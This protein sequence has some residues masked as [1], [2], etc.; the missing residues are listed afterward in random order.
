MERIH[1]K[2]FKMNDFKKLAATFSEKAYVTLDQ[3]TYAR[4]NLKFLGAGS[5]RVTFL[6]TTGHVLKVAKN[7]AGAAQNE[8]EVDIYTNPK[9]KP[10]VTKIYDYADDFSW[11]VSEIVK[12]FTNES[13][14]Q[15]VA[16]IGDF[17]IYDIVRYATMRAKSPTG[18]WNNEG[19][20]L[21]LP[22]GEKFEIDARNKLID[23]IASLIKNTNLMPN[24]LKPA[25]HWGVTANG[26]LVL[27]DYGF[28][29]NVSI[30][31]YGG[32]DSNHPN[33]RYKKI[34]EEKFDKQFPGA[35]DHWFDDEFDDSQKPMFFVENGKLRCEYKM[36]VFEWTGDSRSDFNNFWELVKDER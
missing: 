11:I 15:K 7:A 1:S 20:G 18:T 5:S 4:K 30:N 31:H 33:V 28:T 9:T 36:K 6:L 16:K 17:D 26:R 2:T 10:I 21:H 29:K 32:T 24:D 19:G 3:L 13:Q 8:A 34:Q 27:L 12:E 22:Q 23:S 25:K 14:F 35:I